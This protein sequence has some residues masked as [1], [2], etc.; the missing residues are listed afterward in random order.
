M[1]D[2]LYLALCI[3]VIAILIFIAT[4]KTGGCQLFLEKLDNSCS[5]N[6]CL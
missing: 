3:L 1:R 5:Y 2:T 4:I 6:L